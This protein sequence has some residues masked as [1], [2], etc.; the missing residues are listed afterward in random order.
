FIFMET[1]D[2]VRHRLVTAIVNAYEDYEAE[3]AEKRIL[4][5]QER[6]E[7]GLAKA[8]VN[9]DSENGICK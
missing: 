9:P 6:Q 4:L 3:E 1:V 5:R 8:N 2:I 7:E